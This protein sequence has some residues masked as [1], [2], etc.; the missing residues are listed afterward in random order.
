[1]KDPFDRCRKVLEMI[2]VELNFA[3]KKDAMYAMIQKSYIRFCPK[4]YLQKM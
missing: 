3:A 2:F 1:M 4:I